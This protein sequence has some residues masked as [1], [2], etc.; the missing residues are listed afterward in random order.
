MGEGKNKQ[1]V[2]INDFN[3]FMYYHSLHRVRKHFCRHC[4][5]AFI[6]KDVLK[7]HIT[8]CF[9]INGKQ[10]IKMPKNDQYLKFKN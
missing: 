3:R 4:L 2:L 9:Q 1:Y 7:H 5:H 8:Y 10:K 6:T